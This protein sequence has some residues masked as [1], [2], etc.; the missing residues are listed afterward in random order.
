M[1]RHT[2][3]EDVEFIFDYCPSEVI[4]KR[5]HILPIPDRRLTFYDRHLDKTL[6]LRRVLPLPSLLQ[7]VSR[8][9]DEALGDALNSGV[10]IPDDA[11]E[12]EVRF[13]R[14]RQSVRSRNVEGIA[15]SYGLS[16]HLKDTS[17]DI[18]H[19]TASLLLIRP[20]NFYSIF[21]W[22]NDER[23]E[24]L[25][26]F[27]H[28]LPFVVDGYSLTI[29]RLG[30]EIQIDES[31]FREYDAETQDHLRGVVQHCPVLATWQI[32]PPSAEG[33]HI[34]ED[35]GRVISSG[36]FAPAICSTA[37]FLPSP[38][39]THC[40]PSNDATRVPWTPPSLAKLDPLDVATSLSLRRGEPT[41]LRRSARL[42]DLPAPG[43]PSKTSTAKR[44]RS[45][46][47]ARVD[48]PRITPAVPFLR[49]PNRST[50]D[51]INHG[52]NEAVIED[53]T[54]IVFTNGVFERIGIRHRETQTLL[55][56]DLIEVPRS[57][58]SYARIHIGLYIT[59][60]RDAVNR[61]LQIRE[62]NKTPVAESRPRV[63][64]GSATK[65]G[66]PEM[67]ENP[68][69]VTRRRKLK[70]NPP[71]TLES[72]FIEASSR[73]LLLVRL[74][75]G[76]YNS[77]T[78][79]SFQRAGP[80]LFPQI[81]PRPSRR[82]KTAY[83]STE[84]ATVTLG[85][86]MTGGATGVVHAAVL[87][88]RA[89]DGHLA[90]GNVIAKVALFPD[91]QE[92]MRHEFSV[93]ERLAAAKVSGIPALLG[94]FE[95]IEGSATILIMNNCGQALHKT[96]L[97]EDNINVNV[98]EAEKVA[99]MSIIEAIH[100]AGVRHRDV[101]APNLL[102]NSA[103]EATII[104]FDRAEFDPPESGQKREHQRLQQL[105]EG[106]YTDAGHSLGQFEE[107]KRIEKER[108]LFTP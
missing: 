20:L 65:R 6:L 24:H 3:K 61:Y 2:G 32:Y 75:Y 96:H 36:S 46:A 44:G 64:R 55:L 43:L 39:Q 35:I 4:C 60:Y 42:K 101:R 87:E 12:N 53:S 34:L 104:D 50:E 51:F 52:W 33:E 103:G 45:A 47:P 54:F 100:R 84:Y 10:A 85:P 27:K 81:S 76:I 8:L 73:N 23:P 37:G 7:T 63:T 59:A 97:K 22:N 79:A 70:E 28:G 25:D 68:H 106:N 49:A 80:S 17:I 82:L 14:A 1:V 98:S 93:Y 83:T 66:S 15:G 108:T 40:T 105:L 102:L 21:M 72:L 77:V 92:R 95:D 29:L 91:Q 19:P 9:A 57:D 86:P 16:Q 18:L 5:E 74:V 48:E 99:F 90:A 11:E 71:S 38:S 88:V 26:P 78:P 56:S 69:P 30:K 41:S 94:I 62:A 89:K 13:R 67:D 31:V 107:R 58:P